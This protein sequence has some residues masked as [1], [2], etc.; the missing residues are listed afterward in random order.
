MQFLCININIHICHSKKCLICLNISNIVH[1]P[2]NTKFMRFLNEPMKPSKFVMIISYKLSQGWV[3]NSISC[4]LYKYNGSYYNCVS[5]HCVIVYLEIMYCLHLYLESFS[6]KKQHFLKVNFTPFHGCLQL[7]L[8]IFIF[9]AN[10][11][12]IAWVCKYWNFKQ[13]HHFQLIT[14]RFRINLN[15][16]ITLDVK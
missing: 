7:G 13:V 3:E 2:H 12:F 15:L 8:W 16:N 11:E 9:F 4:F 1:I 10:M 6:L 14:T 5:C